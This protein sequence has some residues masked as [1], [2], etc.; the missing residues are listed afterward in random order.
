MLWSS[1]L[2]LDNILK[3]QLSPNP[4]QLPPSPGEK[5]MVFDTTLLHGTSDIFLSSPYLSFA[6]VLGLP[7]LICI[8]PRYSPA[9]GP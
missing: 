7:S 1:V 9:P 2:V 8:K 6:P 3:F 5:A 4:L